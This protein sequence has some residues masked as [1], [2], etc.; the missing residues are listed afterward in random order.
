MRIAVPSPSSR[1]HAVAVSKLEYLVGAQ[2]ALP[3][4]RLLGLGTGTVLEIVF[5]RGTDIPSLVAQ[6]LADVGLT[7]YDMSVENILATGRPLDVR[8]LAEARTSFVCFARVS[9]RRKIRRI[10][11]EYPFL[12]QSWVAKTS[13]MRAAEIIRL[14]GSVEGIAAMDQESAAL[15]L[16]T[17]GRTLH[18]NG[19]TDSVP[20]LTTDLCVVRRAADGPRSRWGSL[21]SLPALALPRF[22]E[23]GEKELRFGE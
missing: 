22:C 8:S 16:V 12:A 23:I 18:D 13:A 11:T 17:S 7:G 19:L 1:L 9:G 3:S 15:V 10:Y 2:V 5:C 4:D 6:G 14:H 21:D 20:I